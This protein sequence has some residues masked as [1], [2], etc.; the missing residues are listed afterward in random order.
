ML[1]FSTT[2]EDWH[3]NLGNDSRIAF[4]QEVRLKPSVITKTSV[5]L[6]NPIDSQRAYFVKAD[7]IKIDIA[8]SVADLL[9]GHPKEVDY[10][11]VIENIIQPERYEFKTIWRGIKTIPPG[12][13]C[14]LKISP[15]KIDVQVSKELEMGDSSLGESDTIELLAQEISAKAQSIAIDNICVSFSGGCDSTALLAAASLL[16]YP[17]SAVTW[18]Y[19]EGSA[20]EDRFFSEKITAQLSVN[21]FFLDVKPSQLLVPPEKN[22][23]TPNVST[24]IAFSGF[25]KAMAEFIA[26]RIGASTLLLN[27]HGGDHIYMDPVPVEIIGDAFREKGSVSALKTMSALSKLYGANFYRLMRLKS[28][29]GHIRK[30]EAEEF[31]EKG[32]ATKALHSRCN[33]TNT[34]KEVHR[35]MILQ[36]IY[37]NST[38]SH[39]KNL[40]F[41]TPFTSSRV[42]ASVWNLTPES[43]FD[44]RET[45]L[46][47]RKSLN[48]LPFWMDNP[49]YGKGHVTGVFQK[50]LKKSF[51]KTSELICDGHLRRENAINPD[52]IINGLSAASSGYGGI[53]EILLK[54][55]CFELMMCAN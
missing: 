39:D 54:I 47:L 28:E 9:E 32:V 2:I 27:G 21:H 55:L 13:L 20:H 49:R 23:L 29:L 22:Y 10:D 4:P 33:S 46:P 16:C 19:D 6:K 34:G 14:K 1:F 17:V 53:S 48:R 18:T 8:D 25:K 35:E 12:S 26:Q 24:S 37:Q 38:T 7:G 11:C 44:Q 45:R 40:N 42:V 36:A 5:E 51:K 41:H 52:N 50:A 15:H 3:S 30:M 43:L 31:F